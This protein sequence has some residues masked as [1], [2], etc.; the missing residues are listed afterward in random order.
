MP[1]VKPDLKAQIRAAFDAQRS[2]TDDP[3]AALDDLA[4]KLT[5]A[6]DAYIKSATILVNFPIP[7]TVAPNLTGGTT[8]KGTTTIE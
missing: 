7:V 1:L 8:A 4:D 5:E 3:E 6:I 2:N